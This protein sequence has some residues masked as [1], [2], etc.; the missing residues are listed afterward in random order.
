MSLAYVND[1]L[2]ECVDGF[3]PYPAKGRVTQVAGTLIR[4]VIP[5]ASIG[6]TCL[7]SN[8]GSAESLPAEVIGFEKDIALLTPLGE[9]TGISPNTVVTPTG[10]KHDIPVGPE[11]RGRALNG[12][13]VPIDG[14]HDPSEHMAARY[15]VNAPPP[16]PLHRQLIKEPL[17]LGIKA[18]DAFSTCGVGQRM[19]IFAAAGVGKSTLMGMLVKHAEVDITI[20]ALIGERGREVREFIEQ[21]LGKEGMAK[22]VVVVATSDRP[23]MERVKA[24]FVATTIAEYFRDQ[25]LRVM[26]LMDSVTRFAR[27]QRE[28]GL[29]AGE[30]PTRRGFP[31]SVFAVLPKLMERSGNS[32]KGSITAFYTV[33]VEGDDMNEPVADETRSILDGHILLS[34]EM[35]AANQYPAIDV[36]NSLSRVMPSVVDE[37]HRQAAAKI[38]DLIAKYK[39]IELLI[40]VGEYKK[41][42]DALADEAIAKYPAIQNLLKQ[43]VNY[44]A[45]YDLTLSQLRELSEL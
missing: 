25:G 45:D 1:I 42:S 32:G 43:A 6:E 16:N 19:G 23:A 37:S 18:L 31:P 15:P 36:L 20:I 26:L 24:A 22:S 17:P 28:I 21:T 29:A 39:E 10:L 44:R 30:V 9:M 27:A 35:A 13:G 11:L 5:R 38:R 8:P 41:G 33:L 2:K 40:R 12:L 14:R 4:A 3:T 34:R 7:L